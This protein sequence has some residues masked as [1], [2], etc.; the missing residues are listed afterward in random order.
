MSRVL[1]RRR[2]ALRGRSG[3]DALGG[4]GAKPDAE[5][6]AETALTAAWIE[7]ETAG[8][9]M[10]TRTERRELLDLLAGQ[11]EAAGVA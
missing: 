7:L 2:A 4:L 1:A 3:L 5:D 8:P 11:R 6:A 9:G 10:A